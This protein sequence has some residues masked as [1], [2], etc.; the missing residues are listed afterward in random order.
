MLGNSTQKYSKICLDTEIGP[1]W[2]VVSVVCVCNFNVNRTVNSLNIGTL[3]RKFSL[4][5]ESLSQTLDFENAR[6]EKCTFVQ[7]AKMQT[8]L[9]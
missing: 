6:I 8:I 9:G 1:K 4:N 3:K 5:E 7:V 2:K